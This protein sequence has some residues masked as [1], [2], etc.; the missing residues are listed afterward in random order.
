MSGFPLFA[1][2]ATIVTRVLSGVLLS[3]ALTMLGCSRGSEAPGASGGLS[4]GDVSAPEPV[5]PPREWAVRGKGGMVASAHALATAAGIEILKA[6]GNAADALPAVQWALNVVEPQSSGMGGG[7]F[8]LYYHRAS[9]RVFALDGR[10]TA[11]HGFPS[12]G[13]LDAKGKPTRFYPE[14]ITGGRPAGVPGTPALMEQ[15]HKRFGSGKIS[16][17][18]TFAPAIRLAE[19]GFRVSPR[20]AFSIRVNLA[21][22]QKFSSTRAVFLR[23]GKPYQPGEVLRQPDLARTMRLLASKGVREFYHGTIARDIVKAVRES[24]G[25]PGYMEMKDLATYQVIERNPIVG[26][27][28]GHRVYAMPPPSSGAILLQVLAMLERFDRESLNLSRPLGVHLKLEAEKIAFADRRMFIADPAFGNK[29]VKGLL[30]PGYVR[31]RSALIS[32]TRALPAPYKPGR[33][34]GL[35]EFSPRDSSGAFFRKGRSTTHITIMDGDGNVIVCTSTIEHGFGSA[36][37]VPGRGFLLNNELTDFNPRPGFI[38]S[39]KGG[40]RP[41]SSMSPTLVFR[42]DRFVLGLGSPGGTFIPGSVIAVLLRFLNEGMDVQEAINAPRALHRDTAYANLEL[43][44]WRRP[45]FT[46]FLRGRGHRLRKPE[47]LYPA[48][49]SVQAIHQAADGVL[50]GGADTRREGRAAAVEPL[51]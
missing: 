21:R 16:M 49:G 46:S 6:G 27:F 48:F 5:I 28:R 7:A 14:R 4:N 40:K 2:R 11:P 33:P 41:R 43:P 10:E 12:G 17:A 47:K 35:K 31:R 30:D 39:P 24:S 32:R 8:V 20:L 38:N 42:G 23:R 36:L 13:F 9:K 3:F 29:D 19:K 18:R 1:A 22:V 45:A 44:L 26:R 37:V 50:W 15:V 34:P 25:S 51:D